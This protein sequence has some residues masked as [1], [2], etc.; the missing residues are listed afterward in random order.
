MYDSHVHQEHFHP[1]LAISFGNALMLFFGVAAAIPLLIHLWSR[2]RY[3]EHSFAAMAFLM[4]A[5]RKHAKRIAIENWFLLALRTA[6]LV[7]FVLAIADPLWPT[8]QRGSLP[9]AARGSRLWIVVLDHSYSMGVQQAGQTRLQVARSQLQELLDQAPDGDAFALIAMGR[10]AEIVIGEPVFDRPEVARFAEGLRL[11]PGKA[12]LEQALDRVDQVIAGA[13]GWSDAFE[14]FHVVFLSDMGKV[15]WDAV[16]EEGIRNQIS[17]LVQHASMAALDV[18]TDT[19]SQ[20]AITDVS[21]EATWALPGQSITMDVQL[22]AFGNTGAESSRISMLIDGQPVADRQITWNRERQRTES[23]TTSFNAPGDYIVSFQLGNDPLPFDNEFRYVVRIRSRIQIL[24]VGSRPEDT[25]A[26]AT[27]LEMEDR[28]SD[29]VACQRMLDYEWST[30]SL[31][32]FDLVI[33]SNVGRIRRDVGAELNEFVKRGGCLIVG[34]GPNVDVSSYNN[35]LGGE[36]GVLP[37]RL[38]G[39]QFTGETRLA[40][41]LSHPIVR[42]FEGTPNSGLETVPI[43]TYESVDPLPDGDS[44]IRPVFNYANGAPA[45]IEKDAGEGTCF[46]FTSSFQLPRNGV[47]GADSQLWNPLTVWPPFLPL[48]HEMVVYGL[49]HQDRSRN[50]Q[51]GES[52][53]FAEPTM[54][55][56]LSVREPTGGPIIVTP[57]GR[58]EPARESPDRNRQW[59]WP[60]TEEVGIYRVERESLS[61]LPLEQRVMK[62]A[63]EYDAIESDVERVDG[64]LL[65]SQIEMVQEIDVASSNAMT[66]QSRPRPYQ[67]MLLGLLVALLFES[68][69]AMHKGRAH[70]GLP[71]AAHRRGT[72]RNALLRQT[73]ASLNGDRTYR[74]SNARIKMARRSQ[75]D[76]AE[77]GKER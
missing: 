54:D 7:L 40:V 5:A 71:A 13:R 52:L 33:L 72:G 69:F 51:V 35:R 66:N 43:W 44:S 38:T 58:R 28:L 53:E 47:R 75:H 24:L 64:T 31:R 25:L 9:G 29:A 22:Q 59:Y 73:T 74:S 23:F 34:L 30:V 1:L 49:R 63:V 68:W 16:R 39:S 48:L 15:T 65:P 42:I 12:R 8:S 57:S 17:Q 77:N 19:A 60:N 32:D 62:F 36:H 6:I 2:N 41:G 37:A 3:A 10:E 50:L 46:L 14:S 18:G 45:L 70:D 67:W 11:S 55:D 20:F 26:L 61:T 21:R 4:R 56:S 76:L 27:A